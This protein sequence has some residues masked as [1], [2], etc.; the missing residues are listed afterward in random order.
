MAEAVAGEG[1][2][3]GVPPA[4][5]LP[6]HTLPAQRARSLGHLRRTLRPD[7]LPVP[8]GSEGAP[9]PC[10]P[11]LLCLELLW[12]WGWLGSGLCCTPPSSL[13]PPQ[14][15][16]HAPSPLIPHPKPCGVGTCLVLS[17]LRAFIWS[18]PARPGGPPH[19]SDTGLEHQLPLCGLEGTLGVPKAQSWPRAGVGQPWAPPF[20]PSA[21][22]CSPCS[23]LY[24]PTAL[25]GVGIPAIRMP[26]PPEALGLEPVML[27]V[28]T[29]QTTVQRSQGPDDVEN[30]F[31]GWSLPWDFA[32]SL[33]F[34]SL[35]PSVYLKTLTT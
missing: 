14:C 8:W 3:A 31:P 25:V 24:L 33:P 13:A 17:G 2:G 22:P 12:V 21:Q 4:L 7:H 16:A 23:G 11:P 26:G 27:E 35:S 34:I 10:V 6:E 18:H 19:L 28:K 32:G 15:R 1:R 20:H 9:S 29:E 30:P 5:F